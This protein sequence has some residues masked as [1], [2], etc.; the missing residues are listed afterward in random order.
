MKLPVGKTLKFSYPSQLGCP[1]QRVGQIENAGTG[2]NG[3][4]VTLRHQNGEFKTFSLKKITDLQI[5]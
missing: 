2:P 4:F 3:A 1:K 5:V